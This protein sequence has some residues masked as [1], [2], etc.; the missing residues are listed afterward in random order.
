MK[1]GERKLGNG[2]EGQENNSSLL[3]GGLEVL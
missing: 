3:L 2:L 1:R